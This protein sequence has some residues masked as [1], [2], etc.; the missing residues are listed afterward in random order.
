MK[1][2][3]RLLRFVQLSCFHALPYSFSNLPRPLPLVTCAILRTLRFPHIFARQ[4]PAHPSAKTP[5]YGYHTSLTPRKPVRYGRPSDHAPQP[6]CKSFL[7]LS[8]RGRLPQVLYLPLLRTH[9]G[10]PYR[11]RSSSASELQ[12]ESFHRPSSSKF[13]INSRH[14]S[15][16]SLRS[17]P[18]SQ[19]L[20]TR[21]LVS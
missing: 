3:L 12:P 21:D 5:G 7:C 10:Y 8:Y 16:H 4:P 6:P 11:G 9:G 1:P 17:R 14:P 18:L 20:F 19:I 13:R 15:R 2:L